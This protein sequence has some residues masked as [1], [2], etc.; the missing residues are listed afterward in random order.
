MEYLKAWLFKER[1]LA[2]QGK[3]THSE[4]ELTLMKYIEKLV[5]QLDGLLA[6]KLVRRTKAGNFE[7]AELADYQS[8]VRILKEENEQLKKTIEFWRIKNENAEIQN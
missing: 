3:K 8:Q 7:L 6:T 4:D 5:T 2:E 1:K